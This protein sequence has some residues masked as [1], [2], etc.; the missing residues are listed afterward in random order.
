MTMTALSNPQPPPGTNPATAALRLSQS[1]STFSANSFNINTY[2][3][4]VCNPF[5]INTYKNKGLKVV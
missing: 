2:E 3:F 5:N 1:R 4:R